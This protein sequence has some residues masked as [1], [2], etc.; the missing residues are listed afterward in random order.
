MY[1]ENEDRTDHPFALEQLQSCWGG[2][3]HTC[4]WPQGRR[5][6]DRRCRYSS[7]RNRDLCIGSSLWGAFCPRSSPHTATW[8]HCIAFSRKLCSLG[9]LFLLR[10][11]NNLECRKESRIRDGLRWYRN[12]QR[13]RKKRMSLP[14]I[15]ASG[16]GMNEFAWSFWL[17]WKPKRKRRIICD[18]WV[19]FFVNRKLSFPS[20]FTISI[21]SLF[22]ESR[23]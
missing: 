23:L 20:E 5:V 7:A 12:I 22:E 14:L 18:Y 3:T 9:W 13:R 6:Q 8:S 10:A 17:F 4:S 15:V 1:N 16:N 21:L 2:G 11:S 19:Q